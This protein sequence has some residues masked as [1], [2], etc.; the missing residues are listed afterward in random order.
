MPFK[1]TESNGTEVQITEAE[2]F[3]MLMSSAIKDNKIT[4][5]VDGWAETILMKLL[6]SE[7][8][9]TISLSKIVSL[10]FTIG[11]YYKIFREKN[12]VR[13]TPRDTED[14]ES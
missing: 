10:S 7:M 1:V 14:R 11:Y 8:L 3:S 5:H 13:Y 6:G 12:N 4:E 2:L 9:R